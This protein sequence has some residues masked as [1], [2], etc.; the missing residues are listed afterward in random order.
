M[1]D[2]KRRN[3]LKGMLVGSAAVALSP[4]H[5]ACSQ[6]SVKPNVVLINIDDLGWTDLTCYGSEYY[7]TPNIDKLASEGI[8]FSNAY[9]ACA[10]CSPTRASLLTGRYPARIGV[11]D[12][13]HHLDD[14]AEEAAESGVNPEEFVGSP[15]KKFFVPLIHSLWN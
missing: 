8:K 15:E 6:A 14:G 4:L 1:V 3:I 12:W 2:K 7:E 9:A 5:Q 11:T 10:V 13:I